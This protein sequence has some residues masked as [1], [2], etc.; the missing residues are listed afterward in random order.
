MSRAG[1]VLRMKRSMVRVAHLARHPSRL[2]KALARRRQS[3]PS[4]RRSDLDLVTG[5]A[6]DEDLA[7]LRRLVAASVA[8]DGPIV[9]IGTLAGRTT[10]EIALAKAAHQ[11]I[12]TV[13]VFAWNPW[14]LSDTDHR[15]LAAHSLRYLTA[16]GH[17][18][19][20]VADKADFYREYKGPAPSLVFLDAIHTYEETQKDIAWA[21]GAG[22]AM[23]A[24][25]DYSTE[26]PG[27][28]QAVDELGGPVEVC[29]SVFLLR[30]P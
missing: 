2:P 15:A 28:M 8:H 26:H 23:V 27:V 30:R 21:L 24:G 13:D 9:E 11:R 29:G 18:E 12:I 6:T 16:T 3:M 17:V 4:T 7:F 22:A 14:Q 5:S 19:Q 1:T 25:H 20:I 10:I